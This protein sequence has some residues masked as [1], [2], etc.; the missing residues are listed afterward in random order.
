MRKDSNDNLKLAQDG[1]SLIVNR[2]I[3][4]I[5]VARI[6]YH[7]NKGM[8]SELSMVRVNMVQKHILDHEVP[9]L[10]VSKNSEEHG[11]KNGNHF[12][13]CRVFPVSGERTGRDTP[14]MLP[15]RR[16]PS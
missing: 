9:M 3:S 14:G 11:E 5:D 8:E 7:R 16:K 10:M 4:A 13:Y 6:A 12:H 15:T 2:V 1:V